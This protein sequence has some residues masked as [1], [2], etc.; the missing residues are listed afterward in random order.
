MKKLKIKEICYNI[1]SGGTPKTTIKEYYNGHIPFLSISDIDNKYIYN[2]KKSITEEGLKNSSAKLVTEDTLCLTIYGSIGIPFIV[3][4]TISIPQSI[5]AFELRDNFDL[6]Y[7]YYLFNSKKN[8]LLKMSS[9]GT[10]PNLSKETI[11]NILLNIHS[12]SEQKKIGSFFKELDELIII[13]KNFKNIINKIEKYIFNEIKKTSFNKE[14]IKLKDLAIYIN[15]KAHE[16][17]ITND[18]TITLINSKFI[19][20]NG[21]IKKYVNKNH[22]LTKK[23]DIC[24]V[25]SDV[26]NGKSLGKTYIAKGDEALNQRICILR[27][28]KYDPIVL[29]FFVN[30]NKEI[31]LLNDG[32]SQTNLKKDDVIN[33]KIPNLNEKEQENIKKIYL[34]FKE[35]IELIDN[36]I[37]SLEKIK[38]YYLN[39]IF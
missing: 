13:N 7:I 27:T 33:I 14:T 10:Q 39:K 17:D 29:S 35:Y 20:S 15:G 19:S 37:I 3:K 12:F 5:L 8:F 2:T 21:K 1:F 9:T 25:L 11:S 30:R 26:P 31:L 16:K 4:K 6:E 38:K 36:K 24:L 34:L 32:V 18:G 28:E 22:Q 23:N